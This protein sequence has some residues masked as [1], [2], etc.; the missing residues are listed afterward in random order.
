MI[1]IVDK[2]KDVEG[3]KRTAVACY[4][5]MFLDLQSGIGKTIT[6]LNIINHRI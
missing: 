2:W 1:R 4:S 3:K 6:R 5:F